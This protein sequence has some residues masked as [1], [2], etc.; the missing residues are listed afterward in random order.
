[1]DPKSL[2]GIIVPY[3]FH[4]CRDQLGVNQAT[5]EQETS[6]DITIPFLIYSLLAAFNHIYNPMTSLHQVLLFSITNDLSPIRN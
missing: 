1:M 4:L 3:E 5:C 6:Y 2:L